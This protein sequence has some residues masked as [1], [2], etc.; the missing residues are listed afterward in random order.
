[1][2]TMM[3]FGAVKT[4]WLTFSNSH[5]TVSAHSIFFDIPVVKCLPSHTCFVY[6]VADITILQVTARALPANQTIFIG[7]INTQRIVTVFIIFVTIGGTWCCFC[8][9]KAFGNRRAKVT[10]Y[11]SNM[12]ICYVSVL[13][14]FWIRKY[15]VVDFRFQWVLLMST[16]RSLLTG[17]WWVIMWQERTCCATIWRCRSDRFWRNLSVWIVPLKLSAAICNIWGKFG[18]KQPEENVYIKLSLKKQ[19]KRGLKENI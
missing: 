11:E 7:C 14:F 3:I 19:H 2:L 5:R 17:T 1:M 16:L 8:K 6:N 9:S 10:I 15:F 4:T 18:K 12:C 13:I